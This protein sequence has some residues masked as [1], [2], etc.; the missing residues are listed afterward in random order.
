MLFLGLAAEEE[1]VGEGVEE[2]VGERGVGEGVEEEGEGC[3]T[4]TA[5][6]FWPHCADDI[7]RT[8]ASEICG[9]FTGFFWLIF[10]FFFALVC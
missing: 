8:A 10:S 4:T 9:L 5:T 6:T 7:P 1:V 3:R 2:V